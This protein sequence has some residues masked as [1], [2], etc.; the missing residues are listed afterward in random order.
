MGRQD[1]ISQIHKLS[2]INA[3]LCKELCAEIEKSNKAAIS[4]ENEMY[5]LGKETGTQIAYLM[6]G[7]KASGLTDAQ[8]FEVVLIGIKNAI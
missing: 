4:I 8:A 5:K 3:D 1:K 7:L 2:Q 6:R